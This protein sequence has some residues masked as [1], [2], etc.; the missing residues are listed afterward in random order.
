[1]GQMKKLMNEEA[2]VFMIFAS[3]IT[4]EKPEAEELPVVKEFL[5]VFPDDFSDQP[6]EREVEF[7]I[8][9]AP[10]TRPISMA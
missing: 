8:D 5:D 6:P 9:V 4:E 7:A 1:A 10:G 3:L 2:L